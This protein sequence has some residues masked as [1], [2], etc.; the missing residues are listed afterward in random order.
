MRVLFLGCCY[1]ESQK[2]LFL[3]YSKR[4]YQFAAQN[5][6]EAL[7]EGFLKNETYFRVVSV[8]P[9]ST[10]PFGYMKPVVHSCNFYYNEVCCGESIG[11]VNLPFINRPVD[12]FVVDAIERQENIDKTDGDLCIVVYGL[13]KTLMRCA[14]KYRRKYPFVKLSIIIPDLPEFMGCNRIYKKLGLKDEDVRQVYSMINQFDSYIFLTEK[15][16]DKILRGSKKPY[17]I[18]EGIFKERALLEIKKE[19]SKVILYTGGLVLRYGIGDL[20]EAFHRIP[21]NDYQLWLCGGGDAEDAIRE[22]SNK[23]N[24]IKYLGKKASEEVYKLQR[25]ASL[26]VNPR[27]SGETF[28][29]YSFPSKTME[30]MASGTPTLMSKL[31]CIPSEYDRYLFYFDDESIDGMKNK[32]IE[33]CEMDKIVLS[34]IGREASAFIKKQK[35]AEAQV[36]KIL[37][38]L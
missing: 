13:H 33:I 1:S 37:T 35:N 17:V 29:K 5:F 7:F 24:R 11:Y 19:E 36:S 30:Y 6:Q 25:K 3:E 34:R 22:Y 14:L 16:A 8:P 10:F 26:L 23:D 27:H 18:V 20:L 21:N 31:E 38:I 2:N 28:T 4:G 32:M 12:K 15:M 9:L